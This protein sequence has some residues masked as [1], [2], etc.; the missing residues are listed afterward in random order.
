[1]TGCVLYVCMDIS[2]RCQV[3]VH[4]WQGS[5]CLLDTGMGGREMVG[6]ERRGVRRAL[7]ICFTCCVPHPKNTK[8]KQNR[9]TGW[10]KW[11]FCFTISVTGAL[12]YC[13]ST[14]GAHVQSFTHFSWS[15][16]ISCTSA[17]KVGV[18]IA[19]KTVKLTV[20]H[21][22]QSPYMVSAFTGTISLCGWIYSWHRQWIGVTLIH[23]ASRV[24]YH[25]HNSWQTIKNTLQVC[26][27]SA[28]LAKLVIVT[29]GMGVWA[30]D[31][32]L[33]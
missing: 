25:F 23:K 31:E 8:T 9:E 11:L 24:I 30:S 21:S 20:G 28:A 1:M 7:G 26:D 12:K 6:E 15:C 5:R 18:N 3:G 17:I 4:G 13:F 27:Y 14:G 33:Q 16:Y 32:Y 29:V 19:L 10:E 22:H 2:D